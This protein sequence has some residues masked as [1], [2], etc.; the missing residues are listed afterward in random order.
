MVFS[1]LKQALNKATSHVGTTL[2]L[3][4][5]AYLSYATPMLYAYFESIN[6]IYVNAWDEETYLSYQGALGAMKIPGYWTS[7][8]T[9]YLLQNFGLSGGD[10][11]VLF[12]CLITPLTF[13]LIAWCLRKANIEKRRALIY[14]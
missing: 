2:L 1:K 9:V 3:V 4:V 5:L 6:F 14:S 7:G 11:N 13:L 8:A 12:D 10:I